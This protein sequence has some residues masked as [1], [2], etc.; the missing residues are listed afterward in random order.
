MNFVGLPEILD[1]CVGEAWAVGAFDTI[2]LEIT[3]AILQVADEERAPVI[4]MLL[5]SLVSKDDMPGLVAAVRA[6]AEK[7][8]VPVAL[9]LD[10]ATSLEQVLVGIRVGCSAVMIDAS[11]YPLLDN[12]ALTRQVVEVA[13]A[14][15]V[16]VEAELGHVGG[17]D[18]S[19]V[20]AS[21]KSVLTR[22]EE[23]ERFVAETGVDALAVSIGSAHGPYI[24][25]PELDFER[26]KQL[27]ESLD[28]PLVLHGGSGIPDED[29]R[30]AI[31]VGIDKINVWTDVV[32]PYM[33][34]IQKKLTDPAGTRR[35]HDMLSAGRAAAA[36]VVREKI[37]LFGSTGK[38]I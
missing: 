16:S 14:A 35:I 33:D 32:L 29:M 5:P 21:A 12:I 3:Q 34:A 9:H 22:V 23:A 7:V 26:L 28:I 31:A 18:E 8:R 4:V 20:N 24:A 38:V 10:H 11:S 37:R 15:G 2:N 36:E 27:R 19:G 30:Q 1:Q 13:H 25:E 6:E 17:G